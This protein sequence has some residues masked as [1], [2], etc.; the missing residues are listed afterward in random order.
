MTA[1]YILCGDK[2]RGT[3][4]NMRSSNTEF[5]DD[6]EDGKTFQ[7]K[8][9]PH[10]EQFADDQRLLIEVTEFV[11][12]STPRIVQSIK[13]SE[14]Y[15]PKDALQTELDKVMAFVDKMDG[16]E[17]K[18]I[19]ETE[20]GFVIESGPIDSPA[21]FMTPN[22]IRAIN[23][24]PLVSDYSDDTIDTRELA[25]RIAKEKSAHASVIS[26][27]YDTGEETSMAAY[28]DEIEDVV[29]R[30]L[31]SLMPSEPR[32]SAEELMAEIEDGIMTPD[33]VRKTMFEEFPEVLEEHKKN[34]VEYVNKMPTHIFDNATFKCVVC[35][36]S[37][38]LSFPGTPSRNQYCT[39]CGLNT[40][41]QLDDPIWRKKTE[42][43][44]SLGKDDRENKLIEDVYRLL[45]NRIRNGSTLELIE[46][47]RLLEDSE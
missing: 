11:P 34:I 25:I 40:M 3:L 31:K 27:A 37:K 26:K 18:S 5:I 43:V 2:D 38:T 29:C 14:E 28:T 13:M 39:T 8:R 12:I 23:G 45:E 44:D 16:H 33:E 36:T 30:V 32:R 20:N 41:Y 42:S 4:A 47:Q 15:T 24:I 1:Y 35:G 9:I 22:T 7:M 46:I 10:E 6:L 19:I 21:Q 17:I